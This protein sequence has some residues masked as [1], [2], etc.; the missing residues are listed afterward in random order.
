M[1]GPNALLTYY[2][3]RVGKAG[4]DILPLE[5][6][7]GTEQVIDRV[8]RRQHAEHVLDSQAAVSD[9]RLSAEDFRVDR[10][11]LEKVGF[12]H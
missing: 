6:R 11:S 12:V 3:A 10:D 9:D 7:I 8:T 2:A 1:L 5:P 4:E